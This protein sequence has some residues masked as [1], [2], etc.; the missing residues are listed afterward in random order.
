MA[1]IVLATATIAAGGAIT[2]PAPAHFY[3]GCHKAPCKRHVIAP[4]RTA[5]LGPVGQCE[6]GTTRLLRH[7]LRAISAS[8]TYRGRYQ[9]D[10]R[11]WAGAGGRGDPAHAT[12][13]EQAY[14][15]VVWLKRAGIGAWPLC[16]RRAG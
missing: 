6:S 3:A 1:R 15:A 16:G 5:F 12:W 9:F 8:G 10:W 7:G 2:A 14:R 11:S 13:L 4:Y